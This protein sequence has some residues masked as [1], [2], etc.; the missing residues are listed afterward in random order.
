MNKDQIIIAYS[1]AMCGIIENTHRSNGEGRCMPS[2][3]CYKKGQ[4]TSCTSSNNVKINLRTKTKSSRT[5]EI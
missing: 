3:F 5:F 1:L 2:L 4:H